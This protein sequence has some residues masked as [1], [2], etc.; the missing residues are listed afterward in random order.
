LRSTAA[1]ARAARGFV[2]IPSRYQLLIF[3]PKREE[4]VMLTR[5]NFSAC[6]ICAV[7][8][9]VATA[10]GEAQAQTPGLKRTILQKVEFP[11]N[12]VT[13]TALVDIDPGAAV[14]RHT[15]PGIETVYVL[16]GEFELSVKGEPTRKMKTGDSFHVP[17]EVPHS[18]RGSDKPAKLLVTYVVDKDKPLASPAPE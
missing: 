3:V 5:R 15:H 8:G 12:Y 10:V 7:A 14:A 4:D 17:R 18:G 9:F 13:V 2:S 11:D 6:A 1:G 16:D